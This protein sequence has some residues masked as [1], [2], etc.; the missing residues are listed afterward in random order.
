MVQVINSA[1]FSEKGKYR[2]ENEDF[3]Y[4][5]DDQDRIF[6][7]C[8]GMG[9]HGHGEIASEIVGTSVF[10]Y[11]KELQ[12]DEY[13]KK[14]DNLVFRNRWISLVKQITKKN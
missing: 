14:Y 1:S 12:I 5:C 6:V 13:T 2:K 9:G 4:P 7:L 3:I 8:D 10:R 11:L